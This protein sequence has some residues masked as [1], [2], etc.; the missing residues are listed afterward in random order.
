[1]GSGEKWRG[2]KWGQSKIQ[3]IDLKNRVAIEEILL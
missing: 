1:M 2:E 3:T